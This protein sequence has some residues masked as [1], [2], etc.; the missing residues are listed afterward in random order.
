M[1][2]MVDSAHDY[3]EAIGPVRAYLG[4]VYAPLFAA[5][6]DALRAGDDAQLADL[7]EQ[8]DD[9][10][11]EAESLWSSTLFTKASDLPNGVFANEAAGA[12]AMLS[13][14]WTA[15]AQAHRDRMSR[16]DS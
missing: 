5:Y 13:D 15:V 6:T 10:A 8:L 9:A 14:Q 16:P 1:V 4:T 7:A 11:D 12:M 3:Q 2:G